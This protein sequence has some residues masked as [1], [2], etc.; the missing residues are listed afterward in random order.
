MCVDRR[1]DKLGALHLG[2]VAAKVHKGLLAGHHQA[3]LQQH[4]I[5]GKRTVVV[6]LVNF[7]VVRHNAPRT[8]LYAHIAAQHRGA[9]RVV[10]GLRRLG[11]DRRRVGVAQFG[12]ERNGCHPGPGAGRRYLRLLFFRQELDLGAGLPAQA[13]IVDVGVGPRTRRQTRQQ[14][15]Q[16]EQSGAGGDR[17]CLGL[18][19]KLRDNRKLGPRWPVNICL[20]AGQKAPQLMFLLYYLPPW[21][22][23]V[24]DV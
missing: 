1:R 16:P 6:L 9:V 22:F 19:E 2:I 3:R 21:G 12:I 20:S 13:H 11:I 5:A 23:C 14:R 24:G 8:L 17:H 10:V 15:R 7:G 4:D 18:S